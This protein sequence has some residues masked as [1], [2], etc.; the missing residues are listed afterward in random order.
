MKTLLSEK[1]TN[2]FID[3]V[4]RNLSIRI[5]QGRLLKKFD[6]SITFEELLELKK[7]LNVKSE[8]LKKYKKPPSLIKKDK[9]C[10]KCGKTFSTTFP[11]EEHMCPDCKLTIKLT[12][13]YD[14]NFD[15]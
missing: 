5:I 12:N 4:K 3:M 7:E 14:W 13:N 10:L 15:W 8:V 1:V 9:R 2:D 6:I 11:K